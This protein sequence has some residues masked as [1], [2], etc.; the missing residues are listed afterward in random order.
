[1]S[2]R[3]KS[4]QDD[5]EYD[6]LFT[7]NPYC[8]EIDVNGEPVM[9]INAVGMMMEQQMFYE[10]VRTENILWFTDYF[11]YFIDDDKK[12]CGN[13]EA[14]KKIKCD[15]L[16]ENQWKEDNLRVI[17][18]EQ[19]NVYKKYREIMVLQKNNDKRINKIPCIEKMMILKEV[20]NTVKIAGKLDKAAMLIYC[21]AI[22]CVKG[23]GSSCKHCKKKKDVKNHDNI[24]SKLLHNVSL[25]YFENNNLDSSA[26]YAKRALKLNPNYKKC[27]N[28]L[29][30]INNI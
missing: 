3:I 10:K 12:I 21:A 23:D 15:D 27:L 11:G 19:S 14:I 29:K 20:G 4:K 25:L 1:M 9:L 24:L 28:R 16:L 26:E 6:R 17:N 7:N 8:Q 13:V 18:F 30:I 5:Q 2:E 22:S